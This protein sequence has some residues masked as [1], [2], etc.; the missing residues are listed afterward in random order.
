MLKYRFLKGCARSGT[1]EMVIVSE[2]RIAIFIDG[3]N[4][5]HTAPK[6]SP[7]FKVHYGKL[8]ERLVAGRK[9]VRPYFYGPHGVPP[10]KGQIQFFDALRHSGLNVKTSPLRRREYQ[11]PYCSEKVY[12]H[13]EKG[14]DVAL[15]TDMLALAFQNTYDTAIVVSGDNDL[16]GAVEEI[17]RLGKRVEV[18]AFSVGIGR[19]L[20]TTADLYICLDEIADEIKLT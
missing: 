4:I 6:F 14:V 12:A 18:A 13:V 5:F 3:S 16:I 9:L 20:K 19:E 11:C 8:I 2:E 1:S 7:G 15:V 10:N 17:Q